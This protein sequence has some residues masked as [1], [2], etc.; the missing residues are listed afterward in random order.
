MQAAVYRLSAVSPSDTSELDDANAC[1]RI[2]PEAIV[3]ALVKTE[4]NSCVNDFTRGFVIRSSV[5]VWR[6]IWA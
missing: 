6:A 4:S 5:C 2:C 1:G 3:A